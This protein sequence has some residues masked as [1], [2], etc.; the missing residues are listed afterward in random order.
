MGQ[1]PCNVKGISSVPTIFKFSESSWHKGFWI[2]PNFHPCRCI[3]SLIGWHVSSLPNFTY[4]YM[5]LYNSCEASVTWQRSQPCLSPSLPLGRGCIPWV[6]W[7]LR[8]CLTR[9][10]GLIHE[11]KGFLW[12]M[13]YH[14]LST[15]KRMFRM[16]K[17]ESCLGFFCTETDSI[18]QIV[19][20]PYF[21]Y[22]TNPLLRSLYHYKPGMTLNRYTHLEYCFYVLKQD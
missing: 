3:L 9:V 22:I 21:T 18:L 14:L 2:L 7:T 11:Q 8:N 12:K 20:Y 6:S 4:L 19:S 1:N 16:N 10:P 15:R 5:C 17:T 13:L